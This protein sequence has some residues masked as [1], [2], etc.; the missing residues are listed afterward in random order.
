MTL[1]LFD[2]PAPAPP[3]K[4]KRAF[5]ST[6]LRRRDAWAGLLIFCVTFSLFFISP[7]YQVSDSHYSM[8]LSEN[9][10][11]HGTFAMDRY[12]V[13]PLDAAKYPGFD[14]GTGLPRYIEVKNQHL[15]SIMPSGG[16]VLSVPFVGLMNLFGLSAAN[17]DN[18]YSIAGETRIETLLAALLMAGLAW[19]FFLTSRELLPLGWSA[20]V[21]LSAALGTPVWSTASRAMWMHTW[22]LAL[23]G[24]AIFVLVRH[25]VRRRSLNPWLFATLLS[26]LFYVRPANALFIVAIAIYM[27]FTARKIFLPFAATGAAWL[28]L[29][30]WF[31]WSRYHHFSSTYSGAGLGFYQYDLIKERFLRG[32]VGLLFS[33]SRGYLVFVPSLLYV[34]YT[35]LR[36]RKNLSHRPL[37]ALSW[38]CI[39]PSFIMYASFI[40]WFAGHSYGPRYLTDIIPWFFLLAL[41]GIHAMRAS[42]ESLAASG[43]KPPGIRLQVAI[44]T[45][46][47]LISLWMNGYGAFSWSAAAWNAVPKD[48]SFDTERLWDWRRPQWLAGLVPQPLPNEFP[49]LAANTKLILGQSGSDPYLRSGYGWSGAEDRFRRTD[50][51]R[52]FVLFQM[53]P[54]ATPMLELRLE[55]FLVPPKLLSQRLRIWLN[56][57]PVATLILDDWRPRTYVVRIPE[58]IMTEKNQLRIDLP[59]VRTPKSLGMSTDSRHLGIAVYWMKISS[60]QPAPENR[61]IICYTD[62]E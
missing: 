8:L 40:E 5:F 9:L 44:A 7:V 20:A 53:T 2:S 49:A 41:L 15:Y 37:V 25:A 51:R 14:A 30:L 19:L 33:P 52:A 60:E 22:G 29:Y 1:N 34:F 43:K 45:V 42:R 23:T 32:V 21:A 47:V 6:L 27:L 59:D 57:K 54:P 24:I 16:S 18:T 35:L 10:L 28:G 12:F 36:Y 58:G 48:I 4:E 61:C 13:Q 50:G 38:A 11:K 31:T 46:L 62:V 56:N 55:P 17:P 3:S 26:W 39:I